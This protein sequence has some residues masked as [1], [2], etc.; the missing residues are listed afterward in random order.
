MD[1][2]FDTFQ[3]QLAFASDCERSDYFPD[4]FVCP[5]CEE[6]LIFAQGD[7]QSAHFKH[8]ASAPECENRIAGM[9]RG[10]FSDIEAEPRDATL[11]ALFTSIRGRRAC[12]FVLRYRP[13]YEIDSINVRMG[14]RNI[15]YQL[16]GRS[17]IDVPV[18]VAA[19]NFFISAAV[20]G[21]V[22]FRR[23]TKAFGEKPVLFRHT[24]AQAV[25]V[26]ENRL[27]H[28][29]QYIAC[30]AADKSIQFPLVCEA[31][32]IS[33]AL[34]ITVVS[35]T[36]PA[37]L[38]GRVISFCRETFGMAVRVKD[39]NCAII[40]PLAVTE[41][42]P[43]IW[44]TSEEGNTEVLVDSRTKM[45]ITTTLTVQ[46][47]DKARL[48]THA[49]PITFTETPLLL[50]FPMGK[51]RPLLR[52]GIGNPIQFVTELR[53]L[54][55]LPEPVT[56][57]FRFKF[58]EEKTGA[59]FHLCRSSWALSEKL[60]EVREHLLTVDSIEFPACL[61]IEIVDS[62]KRLSVTRQTAG[63]VLTTVLRESADAVSIDAHGYPP[64]VVLRQAAPRIAK[65][66]SKRHDGKRPT[67]S[68]R[69][70]ARAFSLGVG[71]RY[72]VFGLK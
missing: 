5:C 35:F 8:R 17:E 30:F 44:T 28:P 68:R 43:D 13:G 36:I 19:E 59:T 16:H 47:R 39:F 56:S 23:T 22:V 29:G 1:W 57:R 34:D 65:A 63:D 64:I 51:Q 2:A 27:L 10:P 60:A 66:L 3:N 69:R 53:Y 15:G 31:E 24:A 7:I 67:A 41:D 14:E 6:T 40:T 38:N 32:P 45:G 33:C 21:Q 9:S 48:V 72:S 54:E 50:R 52:I 26:P 11:V 55:A 71:S 62:S 58:R 18:S 46:Y 37:N 49:Q 12:S 4:R 70:H 61:K 20:S 42:T 25:R